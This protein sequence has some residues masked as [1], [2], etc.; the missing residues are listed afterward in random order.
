MTNDLSTRLLAAIQDISETNWVTTVD[1]RLVDRLC[2]AH[3]EIIEFHRPV[4]F[5]DLELGLQNVL[6]CHTCHGRLDEPEGWDGTDWPYPLVQM[7]YPC[8]TVQ[9]L[10]R[11]Y[12][13]KDGE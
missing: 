9:S 1:P 5:T 7:F 2:Q 6:V 3:R 12:G 11:A 13:L 4:L 10:A 8:P